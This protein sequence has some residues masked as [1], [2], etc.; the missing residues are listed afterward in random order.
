LASFLKYIAPGA[1]VLPSQLNL[2]TGLLQAK[3]V[4]NK[5]T[6]NKTETLFIRSRV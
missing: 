2:E 5:R 4:I 1:T 6:R 3:E